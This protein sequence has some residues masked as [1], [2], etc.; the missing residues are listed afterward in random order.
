MKLEVCRFNWT[1]V[2]LYDQIPWCTWHCDIVLCFLLGWFVARIN[3]FVAYNALRYRVRMSVSIDTKWFIINLFWSSKLQQNWVHKLNLFFSRISHAIQS[4]SDPHIKNV[5]KYVSE[6]FFFC[7][8]S[9]CLRKIKA[10]QK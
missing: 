8:S 10:L 5:I 7:F 9:Y 6:K 2:E 4:F 3:K 1:L